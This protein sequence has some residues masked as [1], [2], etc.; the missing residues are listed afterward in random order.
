[1]R[2]VFVSRDKPIGHTA[3]PDAART[4]RYDGRPLAVKAP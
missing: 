4:V 2:V 1:V 3:G